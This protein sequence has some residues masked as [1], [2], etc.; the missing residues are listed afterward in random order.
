MV[1]FED[2]DGITDTSDMDMEINNADLSEEMIHHTESHNQTHHIPYDT[3]MSSTL[4]NILKLLYEIDDHTP[5]YVDHL[6]K[7]M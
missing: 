6:S 3:H 5:R 4:S 7:Y 1:T 2:G